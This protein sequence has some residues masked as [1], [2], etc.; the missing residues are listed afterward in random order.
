MSTGVGSRDR[1]GEVTSP[2]GLGDPTPTDLTFRFSALSVKSFNPPNPRFRQRAHAAPLGLWCLVHTAFY[3]HA[4]P[5][6]LNAA[7]FAVRDP[8]Y[9]LGS[10]AH[11]PTGW[12]TQPLRIQPPLFR[13]LRRSVKY[14]SRFPIQWDADF[15]DIRRY[16][17]KISVNQ[18]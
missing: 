3:K 9:W 10:Q 2:D 1:R 8:S 7:K 12:V 6:G 5:L 18:R 14:P 16:K 4:A 17:Q 13:P 11:S 15:A